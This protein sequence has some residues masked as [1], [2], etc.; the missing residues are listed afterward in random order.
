MRIHRV[1]P[2]LLILAC[3]CFVSCG[4]GASESCPGV[5]C[6]NCAGDCS[7]VNITCGSGQV[8]A[9]VGL[10]FFTGEPSAERCVFCSSD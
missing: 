10:E 3:S 8:E 4:E 6:T 7:D 1:L 5:L 9:C 2:A